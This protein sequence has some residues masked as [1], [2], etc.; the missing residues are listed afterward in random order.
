MNMYLRLGAAVLV[1][2][3]L[4]ACATITR[5][6]KTKYSIVSEPAG[7]DV[8]LTTGQTCV[9]PCKIKL[10]R[11]LDFTAR[12]TKEGYEPHET[13]VESKLSGGGGVAGAGNILLGGVIGGIVDGTNGSM[14]SLFPD[15]IEA[16]LVPVAAVAPIA[17]PSAAEPA[18]AEPAMA[19]PE[20]EPPV[21]PVPVDAAEPAAAAPAP[22]N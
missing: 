10:K 16:K 7:A 3:S 21:E 17:D 2:S 22:L 8:M 11:K 9:T 6:T 4:S 19:K 5:G 12:I 13:K 1:V 14:N 18:A 15:K 20:V